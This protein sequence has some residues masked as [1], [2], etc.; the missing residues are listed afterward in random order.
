MCCEAWLKYDCDKILISFYPLQE[1]KQKYI[2]TINN[3]IVFLSFIIT[4]SIIHF[5]GL[6]VSSIA[7][8]PFHKLPVLEVDGKVLNQSVAIAR[9]LGKRFELVSDDPLRE[10][11]LEALIDNLRDLQGS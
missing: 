4:Q 7:A 5:L 11:L 9:Y 3:S 2:S 6:M 8:Y 10:A 1:E